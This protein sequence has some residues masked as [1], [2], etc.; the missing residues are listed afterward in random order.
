MLTVACTLGC[1]AIS[2]AQT[3]Y[4]RGPVNGN[5]NN[6][7]NWSDGTVTGVSVPNGASAVAIFDQ[8]TPVV[9][10]D[11]ATI[12]LLSLVVT[13]NITAKLYSAVDVHM[14]LRGTGGSNYALRV[15]ANSR[16]EDSVSANVGFN[17]DIVGGAA[18][19]VNGTWYLG[20]HASAVGALKGP[21]FTL[22][23][24]AGAG[25]RLDVNG[26][27]II[28]DKGFVNSNNASRNYLFFNANSEF[29]ITRDGGAVPP[30]TWVSNSSIH[31][32]GGQIAVATINGPATFS[33]GNLIFDCPN[34]A[35]DVN[36]QLPT[37]MT[38]AGN[39]Q[40]QNTNG[41][42]LT[43]AYSFA[44]AP[45]SLNYTVNGN[46]ELSGNSWVTLGNNNNLSDKSCVLQVNGNFTQS[47]GR[48]DLR[49]ANITAATLPTT[50]KIAGNFTQTAGIF[51]CASPVT[52]IDLFVVELNGSGT[53]LVD[54][55]S[56]TIDNSG[57]Q[58]T[59]RINKT[60]GT[61]SMQKALGVG[62]LS[63]TGSRGI[64]NGNNNILTVNNVEAAAVAGAASDGY[65]SGGTIIRNTN[66]NVAY[67]MPVGGA[68]FRPADV[69]PSG[70]TPSVY[71][72]RYNGSAYAST[73][74]STP[75]SKVS[76]AEY[77]DIEKVSGSD[78]AVTLYLNG[79]AV[80]GV[81]GPD[82]VVVAHYNTVT[83]K[84][85][86]VQEPGS[87]ITP[88]NST[89]GFATSVVMS[90][91]SPFTFGVLPGG[92]LPVYLISFN[93]KKLSNTAAKLEWVITA[94]SNPDRFEILR[95]EDGVTFHSIGTVKAASQQLMFSYVDNQLPKKTAYYQ[96]RM[97][98]QQGLVNMSK[99]VSVFNNG[100]GWII[101]SMIPTLV[102]SQAK[103]NI[104]ASTRI[105][106]RLVVTDSYGRIVHQQQAALNAGGSQDIWLNL[107]RLAAGAYQVT[108]YLDNGL[109]T[110]T[111]RFIKQ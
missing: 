12:D 74:V 17:M 48:F 3:R 23:T 29:L 99:I 104:S 11:I 68:S 9:N 78:A 84:W 81:A 39:L 53:Q 54:L 98:D 102:T 83:S 44:G 57:H 1:I 56:N 76:N 69:I 97:I 35:N 62:R 40:V 73:A 55:S 72:A 47:A 100:E 96:L 31:I 18:A 105:N 107:G 51:G 101:N 70:A 87:E 38:V 88:G 27:V 46:F 94:N 13:N 33:I 61:A 15:D 24:V 75:L 32:T 58:V 4:W 37:G 108:G 28:A 111:F 64:I 34:L 67:Q 10:V 80:P 49:G 45:A 8:G 77:W 59:L 7:A 92:P 85:E 110:T 41:K 71:S 65:F 60:A 6:T 42:N 26:K 20:G 14:Y 22:P 52:G 79:T 109:K 21:F 2:H 93:A 25:T 19:L 82:K 90:S 36:W 86:N 95:S 63:W 50:L 91:F 30:A 66:S 16:L 5:W 89:T 103:L 43:L 106:M